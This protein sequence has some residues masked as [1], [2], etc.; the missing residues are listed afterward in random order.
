MVAMIVGLTANSLAAHYTL[1]SPDGR[2]QMGIY[3]EPRLYY[4]VSMDGNEV[5]APSPIEDYL[6]T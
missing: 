5:I 2:L 1:T 6:F 3:T 4:T